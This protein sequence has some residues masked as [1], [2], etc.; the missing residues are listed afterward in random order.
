MVETKKFFPVEGT[1]ALQMEQG[2]SARFRAYRM[3]AT[4]KPANRPS[5]FRAALVNREQAHRNPVVSKIADI[6]ASSEFVCSLMFEDAKG[7][8]FGRFSKQQAA[9]IVAGTLAM[10]ALAIAVGA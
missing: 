4:S 6:C 3:P 9:L 2:N 1:A 8:A 7:C 5:Q 10:A